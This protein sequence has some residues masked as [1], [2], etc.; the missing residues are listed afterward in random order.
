MWCGGARQRPNQ[1]PFWTGVLFHRRFAACSGRG[2]GQTPPA[3]R[4]AP[5]PPPRGAAGRGPPWPQPSSRPT[6]PPPQPAVAQTASSLAS[7]RRLPAFA[8]T[9]PLHA[10]PPVDSVTHAAE[11]GHPPPGSRNPPTTMAFVCTFAGVPLSPTAEARR[12]ARRPAVAMVDS[13]PPPARLYEAA[14][15]AASRFHAPVITLRSTG[16]DVSSVV[17]VAAPEVALDT[18][19]AAEVLATATLRVALTTEGA[20][21]ALF[22]GPATDGG[23][24]SVVDRCYPPARRYEA[25]VINLDASGGWLS[26][27]VSKLATVEGVAAEATAE[28]A[29]AAASAAEGAFWKAPRGTPGWPSSRPPASAAAVVDAAFPPPTRGLAPEI[30]FAPGTLA[31]SLAMTPATGGVPDEAAYEGYAAKGLHCA[32]RIELRAPVGAWDNVGGYIS[33]SSEEVQ[34]PLDKAARL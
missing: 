28:A 8:R 25:P 4:P 22:R 24:E 21:G 2:R 23:A 31:V 7:P 26:V 29:A 14:Y 10:H 6:P 3:A 19:A 11:H 13:P 5:V 20:S 34:L 1:I 12:C 15:P 18:A 17:A 9:Y 32:P 30:Q 33:V 16:D 27:A